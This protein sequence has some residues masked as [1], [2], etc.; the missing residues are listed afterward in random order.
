MADQSNRLQQV[1]QNF[2]TDLNNT[3]IVEVKIVLL[4]L[5]DLWSVR[6]GGK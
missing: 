2:V 1:I 4:L 5:G 6:E 3:G